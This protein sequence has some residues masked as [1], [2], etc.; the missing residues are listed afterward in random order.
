M[1]YSSFHESSM[2]V[3]ESITVLYP[4]WYLILIITVLHCSL[5]RAAGKYEMFKTWTRTW[6]GASKERNIWACHTSPPLLCNK[7]C[8][9]Q[10]QLRNI[11]KERF[12]R[13]TTRCIV[14]VGWR[15]PFAYCTVNVCIADT[16]LHSKFFAADTSLQSKVLLQTPHCKVKFG[17]RHFFTRK[18]CAVF[19]AY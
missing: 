3:K 5:A 17:W 11:A 15:H 19:T 1:L 9:D 7:Y 6:T 14:K 13:K 18:R 12:A 16:S 4:V 8:I 2:V 10:T